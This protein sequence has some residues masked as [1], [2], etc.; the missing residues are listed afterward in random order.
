MARFRMKKLQTY[1]EFLNESYSLLDVPMKAIG[2]TVYQ[3]EQL[4]SEYGKTASD[5]KDLFDANFMP[6]FDKAISVFKPKEKLMISKLFKSLDSNSLTSGISDLVSKAKKYK[7]QE[8][9]M[10]SEKVNWGKIAAI[11]GKLLK[12][13]A[14]LTWE[15]A[16]LPLLK[17]LINLLARLLINLAFAIVNAVFSTSY[18]APNVTIFKKRETAGNFSNEYE[19]LALT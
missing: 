1:N 14:K 7:I 18:S 15:R 8:S 12:K 3:I 11:S 17:Y 10:I 2:K 16:I 4:A 19:G 13:G 9:V 5:I 6:E